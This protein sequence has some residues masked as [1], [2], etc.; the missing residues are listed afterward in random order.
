MGSHSKFKGLFLYTFCPDLA[1]NGLLTAAFYSLGF[2]TWMIY[3]HGCY[4]PYIPVITRMHSWSN[5]KGKAN[6]LYSVV[7]GSHWTLYTLHPFIPIP[8]KLN[9]VQHRIVRHYICGHCSLVDWDVWHGV[10]QYGRTVNVKSGLNEKYRYSFVISGRSQIKLIIQTWNN[11]Q[12]K[13]A[14]V[15]ILNNPF[16]RPWTV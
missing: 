16:T 2:W 10:N 6:F 3:K 14:H 15:L 9:K 13:A 4:F 11:K 7:F 5:K 12:L 8:N 1:P